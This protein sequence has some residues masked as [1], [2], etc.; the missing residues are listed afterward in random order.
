MVIKNWHY[1]SFFEGAVLL[2]AEKPIQPPSGGFSM[3]G[4]SVSRADIFKTSFTRRRDFISDHPQV[5]VGMARVL[6][7]FALAS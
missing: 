7:S 3:P 2:Q 1:G 5:A 6:G 4:E